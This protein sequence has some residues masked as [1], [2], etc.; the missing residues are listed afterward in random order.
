MPEADA[1]NIK[2]FL[3]LLWPGLSGQYAVFW[4]RNGDRKYHIQYPISAVRYDELAR[5]AEHADVYH[6]VTPLLRPAGRTES[7]G[8]SRGTAKDPMI[9]PGLWIDVEYR[10][11][12][13]YGI[14]AADNLAPQED[15]L[16]WLQTVSPRP[17]LV[18]H[19][20]HGY[21]AYCLLQ[22]P[23]AIERPEHIATAAA[24]ERAF[25]AYMTARAAEAGITAGV[26]SAAT[27]LAR[28][29]RPAGTI[30][31]KGTPV[32][33]TVVWSDG[34]RYTIQDLLALT[35]TSVAAAQTVAAGEAA[36]E[37]KGPDDWLAAALYGPVVQ[38]TRHTTMVRLAG[39]LLSH[40]AS[41]EAA[42]G[43]LRRWSQTACDPAW[44]ES[45]LWKIDKAVGEFAAKKNV[46]SLP[47]PTDPGEDKIVTIPVRT[48]T[49]LNSSRPWAGVRDLWTLGFAPGEIL[50]L[51][52]EIAGVQGWEASQAEEEY[53]RSAWWWK[54]KKQLRGAEV[55]GK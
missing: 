11:A 18:V 31:R 50:F 2:E 52:Q 1:A 53:R 19:S 25:C 39:W 38:G 4:I 17:T 12:G 45:D 35:G 29:L 13:E 21:H 48:R 55:A 43:V 40:G 23:G 9:L 30:N 5:L 49:K 44:P 8:Q 6:R 33:V 26:D 37:A 42:L 41:Q 10:T 54:R 46:E 20:G 27:D 15:V 24:L 36:H 16:A 51:L 14:H 7:G 32:P 34:P 22:Q 28:V 3:D 47:E